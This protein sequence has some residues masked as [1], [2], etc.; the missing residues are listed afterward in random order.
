[1]AHGHGVR[2]SFVLEMTSNSYFYI[3]IRFCTN[4]DFDLSFSVSL[5]FLRFQIIVLIVLSAF[6]LEMIFIY[7]FS[8]SCPVLY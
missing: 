1:M 3:F 4:D 2:P 7:M 8:V 5:A 6:V